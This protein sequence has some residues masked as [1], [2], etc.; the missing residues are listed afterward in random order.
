MVSIV[1]ANLAR[2]GHTKLYALDLQTARAAADEA[3]ELSS[4]IGDYRAESLAQFATSYVL[5]EEAS[6]DEALANS[7]AAVDLAQEYGMDAFLAG[8]LRHRSSI[9]LEIGQREKAIELAERAWNVTVEN[10][11]ERFTGSWCL[12]IIARSSPDKDRQIWAIEQGFR[13]LSE[14]AA[15]HSH[16]FFYRDIMEAGLERGDWALM[17]RACDALAGYTRAEPLPWS[18]LHI[19]RARALSDFHQGHDRNK[20]VEVLRKLKAQAEKVGLKVVL[21][22]IEAVLGEVGH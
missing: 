10:H 18:V 3:S 4:T 21:P 1:S 9:F 22:P 20:A 17:K 11:F 14:G 15:S 19:A 7:Q 12:S 16:F 5:I 2:I 6:F 13:L 8:A